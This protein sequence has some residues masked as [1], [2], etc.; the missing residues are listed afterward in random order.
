MFESMLVKFDKTHK[1]CYNLNINIK[2]K[3]MK[4]KKVRKSKSTE[5]VKKE[6]QKPQIDTFKFAGCCLNVPSGS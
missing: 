5:K 2:F 3:I 4:N 1:S 6:W